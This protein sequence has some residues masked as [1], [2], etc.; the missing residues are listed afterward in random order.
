[1]KIVQITRTE[2][3]AN[4]NP[5]LSHIKV[6]KDEILEME[7]I[8]ADMIVGHDGGQIAVIGD[9]PAADDSAYIT[10]ITGTEADGGGEIPVLIDDSTKVVRLDTSEDEMDHTGGWVGVAVK[11]LMDKNGRKKLAET[12]KANGVE[13]DGNKEQLARRLVAAGITQI[14]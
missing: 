6:K 12:C 4:P 10:V 2:V 13:T 11:D 9:S 8:I 1:M 7:D 5:A 3:Y 14:F